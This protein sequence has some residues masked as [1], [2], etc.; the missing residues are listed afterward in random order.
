MGFKK[1]MKKLMKEVKEL[2]FEYYK[3]FGHYCNDCPYSPT[4]YDKENKFTCYEAQTEEL[5]RKAEMLIR[6]ERAL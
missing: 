3:C 5:I 6:K 1:E 2:D 4:P